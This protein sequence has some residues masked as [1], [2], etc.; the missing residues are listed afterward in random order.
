MQKESAQ[1][2][3]EKNIH[4]FDI[5]QPEKNCVLLLHAINQSNG[6]QCDGLLEC[7]PVTTG[8]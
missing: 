3:F 1:T 4:L 2:F 5:S 6:L 7:D 8:M